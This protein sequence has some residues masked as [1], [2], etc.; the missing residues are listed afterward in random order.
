MTVKII[1]AHVHIFNKVDGENVKGKTKSLELGKISEG[2]SIKQFLPISFIKTLY[3][4]DDLIRNMDRY[5]IDKAVLLQNPTIGFMNEQIRQ[6]IMDYPKRFAGTIMV[7]PW[8]NESIDIIARYL[9]INQN[10]L[11]FE[12]SYDWGLT[13]I[14]KNL[15][16]LDD[17]VIRIFEYVKNKDCQIIIDPGPPDNPGYQIEEIN[18]LSAEYPN[19]KFIIAHLG[20]MTNK[21]HKSKELISRWKRLISIAKKRNVY[22]ET[23]AAPILMNDKY[24]CE[25]SIKLMREVINEVGVGKLIWGTDAP[26]TLTVYSY[27]EMINMIS[28]AAGLSQLE[29]DCILGKNAENTYSGLN[30]F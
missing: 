1:D 27:K 18:K 11:K 23:S 25:K 16:L 3:S 6:A 26:G 8:E 22:L 2:D 24:P 19:L 15:N 12:M 10:I 29:K 7:Y 5:N 30:Y 9:T 17:C 20:Y 13:G 21:A 28:C 14:H 4:A